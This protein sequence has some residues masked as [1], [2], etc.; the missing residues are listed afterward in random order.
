VKIIAMLQGKLPDVTVGEI[1]LFLY[2]LGA[3]GRR[4]VATIKGPVRFQGTTFFTTSDRAKISALEKEVAELRR[5][6]ERLER[7]LGEKGK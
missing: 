2:P 3:P 7:K 5:A 1:R 4:D 6:V